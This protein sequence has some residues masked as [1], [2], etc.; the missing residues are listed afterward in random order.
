L[1]SDTGG[2]VRIPGAWNGIVTLKPTYGALSRHGLIPLV[3]SLDVPGIMTRC[4]DDAETLF[5]V[6]ANGSDRR[7]STCVGEKER[8]KCKKVEEMTVGIPLEYHCK[9]MSREVLQAWSDVIDMLENKGVRVRRV[10]LPHTSYAI[11]CYS[12]L[13]PCEVASNMARYGIAN[14]FS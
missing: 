11:T 8:T 3:N 10:S 7:D 5:G 2:S 14:S 12:V 6:L 13:N 1:G 4:V 9:D